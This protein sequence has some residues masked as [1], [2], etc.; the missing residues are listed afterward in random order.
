ME[1]LEERYRSLILSQEAFL[2]AQK[3]YR[4]KFDISERAEREA[5]LASVIKHF[6]LFYEMFWKFFKAYLQ[7]QYGIQTI[8]SKSI[9]R[10]CYENKLID[11]VTVEQL[12]DIVEIRNA[13]THV[14]DE[15]AAIRISDSFI[16][17]Y[18][19]MQTLLNAIKKTESE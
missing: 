2:R 11:D 3:L 12:L 17:Y 14:Y 9:F 4:T 16:E 5:Y 1:R 6:E 10:A 18:L 19:A 7:E 13:T 15:E 8:G